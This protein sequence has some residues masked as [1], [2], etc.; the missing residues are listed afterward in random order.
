MADALTGYEV[1]VKLRRVLEA[2]LGS[3]LG[4]TQVLKHSQVQSA[5]PCFAAV[6]YR[7]QQSHAGKAL[8][9]A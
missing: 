7:V 8:R 9:C 2:R 6:P 3:Q 4:L 5:S 1:K